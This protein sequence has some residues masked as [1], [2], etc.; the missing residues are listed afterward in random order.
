MIR[1]WGDS[2]IHDLTMAQSEKIRKENNLGQP[3][4]EMLISA[5]SPASNRDLM[6]TIW[7]EELFELCDHSPNCD[8]TRVPANQQNEI[9]MK[10]TC[11]RRSGTSV[12]LLG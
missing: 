5:M 3:D 1:K 2:Y 4:R 11:L 9:Y 12:L 6:T 10:L 7:L 8:F